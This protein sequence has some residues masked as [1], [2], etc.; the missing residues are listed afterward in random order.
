MPINTTSLIIGTNLKFAT[1]STQAAPG[2]NL[3]SIYAKS[4]GKMYSRYGSLGEE[5]IIGGNASLTIGTGLLSSS[6]SAYNS[7]GATTI[8]LAN[9]AV[10]AGTY[11]N[12]TLIIDAQGRIT[13]ATASTSI[14]GTSLDVEGWGRF[15]TPGTIGATNYGSTGG[16]IIRASAGSNDINYLQFVN[17]TGAAQYYHLLVKSDS[18]MYT[19]GPLSVDVGEVSVSS[20][21][22]DNFVLRTK[23]NTPNPN[24]TIGYGNGSGA[25]DT[26]REYIFSN[27]GTISI[28][29]GHLS[30]A[31]STTLGSYLG[32]GSSAGQTGGPRF[33]V[34]ES[35]AK[36][37]STATMPN[38]KIRWTWYNDADGAIVGTRQYQLWVYPYSNQSGSLAIFDSVMA[39]SIPTYTETTLNVSSVVSGTRYVITSLGNTSQS[40][41]NAM[42]GTSG[43]TYAVNSWFNGSATGPA[44]TSGTV[45]SFAYTKQALINA[46]T[47]LTDSLTVAG[48]VGIGT[49]TPATTLE[50]AGAAFAGLQMKRRTDD[51]EVSTGLYF[52]S[53]AVYGLGTLS[54]TTMSVG[55]LSGTLAVGQTITWTGLTSTVTITAQLTGRTGGQGTYSVTNSSSLSLSNVTGFTAITTSGNNYTIRGSNGGLEFRSGSAVNVGIGTSRVYFSSAGKV[56]IGTTGPDATLDVRGKAAFSEISSYSDT[57]GQAHRAIGRYGDDFSWAP[58][59]FPYTPRS[60]YVTLPESYLGGMAYQPSNIILY[61]NDKGDNSAS[62]FN[63]TTG[64]VSGTQYTITVVGNT[65]WTDIGASVFSIGHIFTYNGTTVYPTTGNTGLCKLSPS[66][67]ARMTI[68]N[69]SGNVGIGTTSPTASLSV[70][71]VAAD[72]YIDRPVNTADGS[73]ILRG[74]PTTATSG[75]FVARGSG[76]THN[77]GGVEIYTNGSERLRITAAGN[78]GI[79]TS[80]A[81]AKLHISSTSSAGRIILNGSDLPMITNEYDVF[82]SGAYQGAGRWGLFMESGYLTLGAKSNTGYFGFKHFDADGSFTEKMQITPAGDVV[83]A[84][85][86]CFMTS[87]GVA[88]ASSTVVTYSGMTI[89]FNIGSCFNA[90]TGR[91]TARVAGT[92]FFKWFQLAGNAV[93]GEFRTHLQKNGS[94]YGGYETITQKNATYWQTLEVS[95]LIQLSANDYVTVYY[96]HSGGSA[97]YTDAGYGAFMGY[98]LG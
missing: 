89:Y 70:N 96:Y 48:N 8:S 18:R 73:L 42:A 53:V 11:S 38:Q 41:W 97:L 67:S 92:Y 37:L 77:V 19:S 23:T 30:V 10:T 15:V 54:G 93:Q 55:S 69:P 95:G 60:S 39:F 24:W 49:T 6:G 31:G 25:V 86:P 79:G 74:G 9:T 81:N 64:L 61:G 3:V 52:D 47:V 72:V 43:N 16:L 88:V 20:G 5:T 21:V 22:G 83:K 71:S 51:N 75:M 17:N 90:A 68:L 4:D 14:T 45:I 57:G 40:Q 76:G 34:H 98:F 32:I 36:S 50:I 7:V 62:A 63:P 27:A 94:K 26:T 12:A 84:Y 85:Q 87:S 35:S 44:A 33:T 56:G 46:P 1:V 2:D 65:S 66:L 80:T 59:V 82:T 58:L 29:S 78:V 13:S 91:F 28:N